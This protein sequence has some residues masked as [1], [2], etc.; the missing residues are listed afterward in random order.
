MSYAA[1]LWRPDGSTRIVRHQ[2]NTTNTAQARPHQR[3]QATCYSLVQ[4]R[5]V[6]MALRIESVEIS[7]RVTRECLA[8]SKLCKR[9]Y[10]LNCLTDLEVWDRMS[11]IGNNHTNRQTFFC[12]AGVC[13]AG[14]GRPVSQL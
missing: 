8:Q 13:H 10:E 7:V 5:Q 1:K 2:P 9:R 4:Y 12:T 6:S 3:P 11:N 14:S